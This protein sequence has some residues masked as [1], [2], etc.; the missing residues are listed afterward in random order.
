MIDAPDKAQATETLRALER[1]MAAGTWQESNFLK[2]IGRKLNDIHSSLVKELNNLDSVQTKTAAHLANRIAARLGKQ[3]VFVSLYSLN[4]NNISVWERLLANLPKNMVSRPVYSVEEQV[5]AMI[6]SKEKKENEAYISFYIDKQDIL[7]IGMEK[8]I[9]DKLG[10]QLITLKDNAI[11]VE[12]MHI[13][14]HLSASYTYSS[15]ILK[16]CT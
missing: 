7:N 1:L 12:R 13:F 9:T 6:A 2:V 14:H 4:G 10:H 11:N 3:E 15:G 5:K 8:H 16:L